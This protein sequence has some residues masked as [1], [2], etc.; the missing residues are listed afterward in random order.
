MVWSD[1]KL[2][3][4]DMYANAQPEKAQTHEADYRYG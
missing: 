3:I 4:K 1:M 2:C